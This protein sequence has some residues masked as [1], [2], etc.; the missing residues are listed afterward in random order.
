MSEVFTFVDASHLISKASLW[1][2]RDRAIKEKYNKLNNEALPKFAK[3]KEANFGCKGGNK[4]WY[5][6][7]KHV[8]LRPDET[9][10]FFFIFF[11]KNHQE[12]LAVYPDTPSIFLIIFDKKILRI[13]EWF[14]LVGVIS[15]DMQSGMINKVAITPASIIDSKGMKHVIPN[16][17]AIYA[18]KG[19]CDKNA[20]RW[21][22]L[23]GI[24]I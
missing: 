16:S 12:N 20:L 24:F 23:K 17:G 14:H 4:F 19:Y 3:D 13:N 7:K 2:E 6:F 18:D 11:V 1:E 21:Q 15:V 9:A 22:Q 10:H 5:G 8:L